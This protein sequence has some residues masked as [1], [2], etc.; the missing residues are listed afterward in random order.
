MEMKMLSAAAAIALWLS[1]AP[2]FAGAGSAS[3]EG[4]RTTIVDQRGER[5]E[6]TQAVSLGFDPEGVREDPGVH[7]RDRREGELVPKGLLRP[8][9]VEPRDRQQ[10][11]R[12]ETGGR[13]VLTARRPSGC[14]QPPDRRSDADPVPLGLD[15]PG[16]LRP[17]RPGNE[18][19]L[20]PVLPGADGDPGKIFQTM[21]PQASLRG[22]H[23]GGV[24]GAAPFLRDPPVTVPVPCKGPGR[25]PTKG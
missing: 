14:V 4:G 24:E 18:Y 23:L 16:H 25:G 8:D 5:W 2:S 6:I 7:P 20:V 3:R 15:V 1:F 22:H 17:V 13:Q 9:A 19:A 21:A 12:R 10:P 11:H